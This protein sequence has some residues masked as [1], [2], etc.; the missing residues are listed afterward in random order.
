MRK[1]VI[2]R[3]DTRGV[4]TDTLT[5]DG[6]P[7]DLTNC[8]VKFLLTQINGNKEISQD[9]TIIDAMAGTV[10]YKAMAADVNLS[11]NFRQEWQVTSGT[12]ILTFPNGDYNRVQILEDVG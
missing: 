10:E 6:E 8:S 2:K 12:D 7:F 9:A 1:I 3:N 11:G 4:F 5:V